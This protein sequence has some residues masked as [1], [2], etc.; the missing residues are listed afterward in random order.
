[1]VA[2]HED[3]EREVAGHGQP[4]SDST[5]FRALKLQWLHS[6]SSSLSQLKYESL[7]LRNLEP[8][9]FRML[10][11]KRKCR[12]HSASHWLLVERLRDALI[13]LRSCSV[14]NGRRG[15]ENRLRREE[16]QNAVNELEVERRMGRT[17]TSFGRADRDDIK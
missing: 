5:D 17:Q 6:L 16:E 10:Q 4:A 3:E 11:R 12:I 13:V 2:L 9:S 14:T 7:Q 8:C 1:M 15:V